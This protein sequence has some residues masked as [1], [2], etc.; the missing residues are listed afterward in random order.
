MTTSAW[1]LFD[2]VVTTPTVELRYAS[3]EDLLALA[4]FRDGRV[5]APGEEPFDGDSSFYADAAVAPAKGIA[6]EW[7][8]RSATSADWWHLSFAVRVGGELV[9]Q[10]NITGENFPI[11][12]TVNSFSFLARDHRRRGI[13]KEMRSAVLHLAFRGL[14]AKRAES[15]AFFDNPASAGVSRSLG[16]EANG[17]M[18]APRPSGAAVMERFVLT[19]E[20]WEPGER[21]DV[22]VHGLEPCLPLLGLATVPA[23]S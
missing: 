18:L 2:L 21:D 13:G 20:R 15:D 11:L 14:D 12:R 1:P 5:V 4:E 8:A 19:R 7:G 17:T 22:E 6:G 16:Y 10:Q 9:G 23:P 3:D